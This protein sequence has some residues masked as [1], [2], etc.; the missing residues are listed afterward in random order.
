MEDLEARHTHG[1]FSGLK[2]LF[3]PLKVHINKK[4]KGRLRWW[5]KRNDTIHAVTSG[6]KQLKKATN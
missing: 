6:T 1:A 4:G 5:K 2:I 3:K